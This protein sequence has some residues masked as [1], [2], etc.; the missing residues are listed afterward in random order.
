MLGCAV[1]AG[2]HLSSGSPLGW[3]PLPRVQTVCHVRM[4]RCRRMRHLA[5]LFTRGVHGTARACSL[6]RLGL[7]PAH[8]LRAAPGMCSSFAMVAGD[9]WASE[10]GILS[11]TP[12]RLVTAPHRILPPGTNGGVSLL[13]TAMSLAG[14]A[15]IGVLALL[16]ALLSAPAGTPL[17]SQAWL[18][19]A[20]TIAGVGGSMVDSVMGALLQRSW[21]QR[22]SGRVTS[23]LPRG[24]VEAPAP[25]G[26]PPDLVFDVVCGYDILSN[27]QVNF[28][29]S[30]LTAA[31]IAAFA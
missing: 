29:S 1:V 27:E 24:G 21:T 5:R 8:V 25:A 23:R 17:A 10:V 11:T 22:S 31:A 3:Q 13:G 30:I 9:T 7:E 16:G 2:W 14:G 26:T 4:V 28:L 18:L 19:T 12:P 6:A 15:F 20:C